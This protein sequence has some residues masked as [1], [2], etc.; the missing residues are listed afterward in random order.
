[1]IEIG[2]NGHSTD[3]IAGGQVQIR[4]S[5]E[6]KI[7]S[8]KKRKVSKN[9]ARQY[10]TNIGAAP[11]FSNCTNDY[12]VAEIVSQD[13]VNVLLRGKSQMNLKPTLSHIN[14]RSHNQ[15]QQNETKTPM[16]S[17][18]NQDD[19]DS[20]QPFHNV[21]HPLQKNKSEHKFQRYRMEP[22]L[23]NKSEFGQV[24]D[25]SDQEAAIIENQTA[26]TPF[27]KNQNE[28]L[29]RMRRNVVRQEQ[30]AN[31]YSSGNHVNLSMA[32]ATRDVHLEMRNVNLKH[33]NDK[34][35]SS[36]MQTET[37]HRQASKEMLVKDWSD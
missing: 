19:Y 15:H 12:N 6:F 14:I 30:I 16:R 8:T 7:S 22:S 1:M 21:E 2:S 31:Q 4:Q 29:Q 33:K 24:Q 10:Q 36:I 3:R 35:V 17:R 11:D 26:L 34:K 18:P 27:M 20:I 5:K 23:F 25:F 37:I 28:Y 32:E 13:E 9:L